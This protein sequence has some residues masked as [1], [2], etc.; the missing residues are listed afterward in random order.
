MQMLK[1]NIPLIVILVLFAAGAYLNMA[2][3]TKTESSEAK[4]H[5]KWSGSMAE[6]VKSAKESNKPVFVDVYADWCGACKVLENKVFTQED[7][8]NQLNTKVVPVRVDADQ[9]RAFAA[10]HEIRALPTLMMLAPDGSVVWRMEGAPQ[11]Q[12]F[13][14]MLQDALKK[15][16]SI[17]QLNKRL[18]DN[19]KDLE[20]NYRLG[21]LAWENQQFEQAVSHLE[22]T[23]DVSSATGGI[24]IEQAQLVLAQSQGMAGNLQQAAETAGSF[25]EKH[26][27]SKH[28]YEAYYLQGAL[29]L[30]LGKNEQARTSLQK[31]IQ[32][33]SGKVPG[34]LHERAQ[35]ILAEIPEP[36]KE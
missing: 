12:Q 21:M 36:V 10:K 34:Y 17:A 13:L 20:A 11:A 35:R 22:K 27:T 23:L 29:F 9:D 8:A 31:V 28:L 19:P 2:T 30:E 25:I 6:A 3:T 18:E 26:P 4:H 16:D 32:A 33:G 24:D 1:K 7:V 15:Y 14:D 5:V